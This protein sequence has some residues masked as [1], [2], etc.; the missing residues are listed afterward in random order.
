MFFN[1]MITN[2]NLLTSVKSAPNIYMGQ[3][4][5][6]V[7]K[8]E[9][10]LDEIQKNVVELGMIIYESYL[11]NK[12]T[13]DKMDIL[14]GQVTLLM[15]LCLHDN[16]EV[17]NTAIRTLKILYEVDEVGSKRARK[18]LEWGA[19]RIVEEFDPIFKSLFYR[20]SV[21]KFNPPEIICRLVCA[22]LEAQELPYKKNGTQAPS[23]IWKAIN[24]YKG[25]IRQF[26][27]EKE[28]N[29]SIKELQ[30][31]PTLKLVSSAN[32]GHKILGIETDSEEIVVED[33]YEDNSSDTIFWSDTEKDLSK[34][35]KDK[36]ISPEKEKGIE[37]K[38]KVWL[39]DENNFEILGAEEFEALALC[40]IDK[41]LYYVK[42]YFPDGELGKLTIKKEYLYYSEH[43]TICDKFASGTDE[44]PLVARSYK[45]IWGDDLLRK[46]SLKVWNPDTKEMFRYTTDIV[47]VKKEESPL[48]D[49]KLARSIKKKFGLY[50]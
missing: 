44:M 1:G 25:Y 22:N 13:E 39:P 17:R 32:D 21:R 4:N 18:L 15:D 6:L 16:I 11:K 36:R 33:S 49:G 12:L 50:G 41:G 34:H 40:W 23:Y 45:E 27:R 35:K 19:L 2:H 29:S 38:Q 10:R 30:T 31:V 26:E 14:R 46:G 7:R 43:V 3:C 47:T 20:E 48:K 28:N 42:D 8:K 24:K 5:P 9:K 37:Y